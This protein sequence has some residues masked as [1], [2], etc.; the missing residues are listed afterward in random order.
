MQERGFSELQAGRL[1][2]WVGILSLVSGPLFGYLSDRLGRKVGLVTVFSIQAAA[3]I[4]AISSLPE[5]F[6]YLSIFCFGI[7]AWSVPSIISALV[8]DAAGPQR[9]AAIFGFVTF[10]FGI[11]QVAGPF[12]AGALAQVTGSFTLSFS[13]AA[14]LG[15]SAA[16]LSAL[17]PPKNSD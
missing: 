4:M 2:S 17:L 11:G 10:I 12:C 1:W 14:L 6:M 15:V 7:V 9:A 16:L 3:Y 8:G 13:L 5:S